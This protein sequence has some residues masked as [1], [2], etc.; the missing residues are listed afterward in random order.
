[1]NLNFKLENLKKPNLRYMAAALAVGIALLALSAASPNTKVKKEQSEKEQTT[2][3][4]QC[5]QTEKRLKSAVE[6][7]KGISDVTVFITYENTGIRKTAAN[8][9]SSVTSSDGSTTASSEETAV[10][11]KQSASEEPFVNEEVLPRVRGVLIVAKGAGDDEINAKITDAVSAVLG[12]P[13][14]KV[15]ILSG[16]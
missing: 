14:H 6:K 8:S 12:V 16:D 2:L 7:V 10:M 11:K 1:M 3:S 13:I 15:K 5:L 4:E 9:T